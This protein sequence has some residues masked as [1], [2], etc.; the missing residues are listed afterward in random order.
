MLAGMEWD[1]LFDTGRLWRVRVQLLDKPGALASLT[2]RLA[3]DG[4]NLLAVS[5]LPLGAD[6]A[7]EVVDEFVLRAPESLGRNDLARIIEAD[8]YVCGGL[9]PAEAGELVDSETA[10]LRAAAAALAGTTTIAEA[11]RRILGADLVAPAPRGMADVEMGGH[12]ATF[13]ISNGEKIVA[14]RT[15]AP[16]TG[17]ELAR[18]GA[19]LELVDARPPVVA[20][21]LPSAPRPTPTTE[22]ARQLSALDTLFLDAESP[23]SQMHVGNLLLLDP[24]D[25]PGR[26]LSGVALREI[27][28]NRLHLIPA[29]RGRLRDVPLGLDLP[30]W[31]DAHYVDL[32]YHVR[33]IA[34]P[35][36]GT[37][38]QLADLIGELA[39]RPLDRRFPLWEAYL[40]SGLRDGRQALY[41]KVHHAVVDGV[42][43]A[44]VLA[45]ILDLTAEP[46]TVPAP[47]AGPV[48]RDAPDPLRML[49]RGVVA[50]IARPVR[51]L[52]AAPMLA[53]HLRPLI[54]PVPATPFNRPVSA[55]R[56]FAYTS[57]P[58]VEVKA[59]KDALNG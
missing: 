59:V 25:L 16:F 47:A 1:E 20:P 6:R 19:L 57:L 54:R 22:S 12:R 27:F 34:L 23:T 43:A 29:L 39:A 55:E 11:L 14:E 45:A 40:V 58:L 36:P 24:T 38:A 41:A 5:V 15:W 7:D 21:E 33:E 10:V 35:A 8:G 31:E 30:Y 17:G 49:G 3:A 32:H 52:R 50:A 13:V 56:A 26:R 51:V 42:S 28:A 2:R 9:T 44:E 4:V 48:Y 46:M 37:D 53:R 18:A